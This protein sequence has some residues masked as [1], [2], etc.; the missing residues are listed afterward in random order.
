MNSIISKLK[1]SGTVSLSIDNNIITSKNKFKAHVEDDTLYIKSLDSG[2]IIIN[3]NNIISGNNINGDLVIGQIDNNEN[4]TFNF[5][6]NGFTINGKSFKDLFKKSEQ[7][8]LKNED[9][10]NE[11]SEVGLLTFDLNENKIE[12]IFLSGTSSLTSKLNSCLTPLKKIKTSGT[13]SLILED[14]TVDFL[15]IKCSG[16]S[17]IK[18][19]N[20]TGNTLSISASGISEFN[21]KKCI[22]KNIE[23]ERSGMA[24]ININ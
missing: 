1:I 13:S 10:L 6:S 22:F 17:D 20:V 15:D 4:L 23:K 12:I 7:A 9:L 18:L 3:G 24:T 21:S 5:G 8:E 16:T 11:H 19:K 2:S 14:L